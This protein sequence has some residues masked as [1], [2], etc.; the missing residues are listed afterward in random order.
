VSPDFTVED[1]RELRAE[2]A[3]RHEKMSEEEID[4]ERR[5]AV[6]RVWNMMAKLKN[7]QLQEN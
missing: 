3:R 5:E 7:L 4:E 2:F 1:I 6:R